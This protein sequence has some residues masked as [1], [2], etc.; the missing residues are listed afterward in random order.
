M[1]GHVT[2]G[3]LIGRFGTEWRLAYSLT[4]SLLFLFIMHGFNTLKI[5]GIVYVNYVVTASFPKGRIS[6]AFAW[7]WSLLVLYLNHLYQGFAFSDFHPALAY[8]VC[9]HDP[10][11]RSN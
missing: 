11:I 5:I 10:L 8:L 9:T 1:L 7:I 4:F 6:V 2:L 3:R